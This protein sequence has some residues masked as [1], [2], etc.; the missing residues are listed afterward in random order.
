[1]T[2]A[3]EIS[4]TS[5]HRR[6]AVNGLKSPLI[7][8]VKLPIESPSLSCTTEELHK[9]AGRIVVH[10]HRTS[11]KRGFASRLRPLRFNC[12]EYLGFAGLGG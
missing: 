7:R 11:R 5:V 12:K 6:R 8:T 2:Q 4:A 10:P 3:A 1:M 9:D